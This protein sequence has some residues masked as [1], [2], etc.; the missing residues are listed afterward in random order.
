MLTALAVRTRWG[1]SRG[2]M[3]LRSPVS[4]TPQ[5]RTQSAGV[6]RAVSGGASGPDSGGTGRVFRVKQ[7]ASPGPGRH[8]PSCGG[9]DRESVGAGPA[10]GRGLVHRWQE[11]AGLALGLGP[12]DRAVGLAGPARAGWIHVPPWAVVC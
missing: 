1:G 9:G 8:M 6:V 3:R 7:W 11:L 12:R 4:V 10:S 5:V 2:A